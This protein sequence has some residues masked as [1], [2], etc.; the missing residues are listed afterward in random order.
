MKTKTKKIAIGIIGI[1]LV[2]ALT[3]GGTLAYLTRQT[4]SRLNNFTVAASDD[5]I[6]AILT[7]PLWD[8][9]EDYIYD[10]DG[11]VTAVYG[12]EADGT[13]ITTRPDGTYGIDQA[14]D[15][16]PTSTIAKNPI[17][18]NKSSLTDIWVAAKMTFVYAAGAGP[19]N[20]GKPLSEED[21]A[22]VLAIVD[23]DY[24][25]DNSGK[26]KRVEGT[27]SDLSQV[28]YYNKILSKDAD[29]DD[30]G[31]YGESTDALF[32]TITIKPEAVNEQIDAVEAIGGFAIFV[33]G[34]AVQS[35][36]AEDYSA[37]ETWGAANVVFN[38]TPTATNPVNVSLPGGIVPAA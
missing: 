19:E 11:N 36:V 9:V 34:F 26:W 2:I 27:A 33:E 20:A 10:D 28:F 12:Y 25:A 24:N 23:I 38:N 6:N 32:T 17:I 22:N 21:L 18:T 37:F 31:V 29:P 35:E 7:E 8:G 4:E 3:I 16:V 5:A 14:V 13:A 1:C 30:V 15:L